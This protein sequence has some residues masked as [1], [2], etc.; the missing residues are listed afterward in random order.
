MDGGRRGVVELGGWARGGG[1]WAGR[2]QAMSVVKGDE[3]NLHGIDYWMTYFLWKWLP[4]KGERTKRTQPLTPGESN[5]GTNS[6]LLL[7][8]PVWGDILTLLATALRRKHFLQHAF[9]FS[10][11]SSHSYTSSMIGYYSSSSPPTTRKRGRIK[12]GSYLFYS[13]STGRDLC[14][15]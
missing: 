6:T 10:Y 13:N 3:N 12:F 7:I 1:W 14:Y 15:F 4:P 9:I 5:S 2:G 11:S 8:A